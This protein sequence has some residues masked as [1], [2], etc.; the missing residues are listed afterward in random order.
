MVPFFLKLFRAVT[1]R[2]SRERDTTRSDVFPRLYES[3]LESRRVLNGAALFTEPGHLVIDAGQGKNDGVAD[4]FEITKSDVDSNFG[5]QVIVNSTKVWE[6]KASDLASIQINGSNDSDHVV[7][8]SDLPWAGSVRLSG[9]EPLGAAADTLRIE[10]SLSSHFDAILSRFESGTWERTYYRSSEES[11]LGIVASGFEIVEDHSRADLHSIEWVDESS[12]W[13]LETAR[14]L[15]SDATGSG[16]VHVLSS[17]SQ[18]I[19]FSDSNQL[20]LK[21]RNAGASSSLAIGDFSSQGESLRATG[22]SIYATGRLSLSSGGSV[23]LDAGLDGELVVSG[24][25]DVS[26][27]ALTSGGRIVLMG[28]RIEL[29]DGSLLDVTSDGNGGEIYVGGGEG[30]LVLSQRNASSVS[31]SGESVLTADSLRDGNGGRI[32]IWSEEETRIEGIGNLRARGGAWSGDG[33]FIETS[34]RGLLHFIDPVLLTASNGRGGLWLVDPTDI[35]IVSVPTPDTSSTA[36]VLA[37]VIE[38]QLNNGVSVSYVTAAGGDGQGDIL[39]Q[40]SITVTG[41]SDATLT[42]TAGRDIVFSA[43]GNIAGNNRLSLQ[44]NA[45]RNIETDAASL[46]ALREL[47]LTA[48]NGSVF[49]GAVSVGD[50]AGLSGYALS[51]SSQILTST[52][53]ITSG[54]GDI[55]FI[56]T[57]TSNTSMTLDDINTNAGDLEIRAAATVAFVG[58]ANSIQSTAGQLRIRG[59]TVATTIGLGNGVSGQLVLNNA[60]ISAIGSGFTSG[61]QIGATGQSGDIAFAGL[62][63]TYA[64]SLTIM[65]DGGADVDFLSNITLSGSGNSLSVQSDSTSVIEL[66]SNITTNGGDITILSGRLDVDGTATRTLATGGVGGTASVAGDV[67]FGASSSIAGIDKAASLLIDTRGVDDGGDVNLSPVVGTGTGI[68]RL[69]I[70]TSGSAT[71][72]TVTLRDVRL[73]RDGTTAAL[74]TVNELDTTPSDIVAAGLI[75]LSESTLNRVGGAIDWGASRVRP[76]LPTSSLELRTRH[77]G[78]AAANNGNDGGSIRFGGV[79]ATGS[80]YFDRIIIDSR[81]AGSLNESG[82]IE[83]TGTGERVLAVDGENGG[84]ATTVGIDVLGRLQ[85]SASNP[86]TFRTNP[87]AVDGLNSLA[88]DLSDAQVVGSGA[89]SLITGSGVLGNT[90]NIAGNVVLGN[91]SMTGAGSSL[92]SDTRGSTIGRT[93]LSDLSDS[94]VSITVAGTFDFRNTLTELIDS[95]TLT[96]LGD[97]NILQLGNVTASGAQGLSLLSE[98]SI[99]TGTVDLNTGSLSI[100]LDTDNDSV[101]ALTTTGAL[102]GSTVTISGSALDDDTVDLGGDVTTTTGALS[103]SNVSSL[104]LQSNVDLRSATNIALATEV[105]AIELT[106]ATGTNVIQITGAS[107]I[108]QLV[109][110][111]GTGNVT[112]QLLSDHSID[113][114]GDVVLS[115]GLLDATI[116]I[117]TART[118]T[119]FRSQGVQA[120][121]MTVRGGD[122]LNDN[123]EFNGS[124]D[125]GDVGLLVEDV[126]SIE[127]DQDIISDG[128]VSL[129]VGTG[130]S[131]LLNADITTQGADISIL[132]GRLDVDGTATRTLST[133]GVGGTATVAGDVLFGST[134]SIAGVDGPASLLVDTRAVDGGGD[135]NL[136]PV[137]GTGTGINRLSIQ[138]SGSATD[139]TVTLRD[140]RL[141][142]DGTTAALFTVNELDTTPSDI[143]AAGLIDLS[144]STL[145]RVGGAIDWGASRV[146]PTLPTSTLE[147]RTSHTGIAVL[148]NG[149]DGGSIRFGGVVATGSDYFDRIIIDSRGAGSL[150]ESGLIELTGT[151]ERVLAVDGENGGDATTVGIDVLGRLQVSASNPLTFRTNPGAVDGLNSL[152]IDLSDAQVVG[153]GALSLI[154][155]SGVLG[156]T[157]NIAGNVVLGNI[158]MTGAG[159]SLTSDTRGSTIGRTQLSDLSDSTVSITVAGTFDFR[160]TL[161]ELI[162]SA[163]LTSLGDANILQLGNVTASGAQGLSLLSEGSISTGTVDLNTGSLSIQLDTDND[164]VSALTTTGALDG[165]T[166]TISGSALDDDTVDLGGDVTTTTGALSFSNVSSLQ[167]QSNVDLRSATNIAF[168]TEV[169]A[170]ELT[171]ATG[172]NVIQIKGA[173]NIMQLVGVGGTGNV[174][175]QLLS[176]HSID[177]LGDVVLSA[178]LLDATIGISTA[179]TDTVF[180]SQGVQARGIS[181]RGNDIAND[182]AEF[183]ALLDLGSSGLLVDTFGKVLIQSNI[184]SSG[185]I[186]IRNVDVEVLLQNGISILGA[187]VQIQSNVESIRLEGNNLFYS[188]ESTGDSN[189]IAL[190]DVETSETSSLFLASQQ[191]IEIEDVLLQPSSTLSIRVDSDGDNVGASLSANDLRAGS[192][193]IQG[194]IQQNDVATISGEVFASTGPLIVAQW[195]TIDFGENVQ[196]EANVSIS[197]VADHVRFGAATLVSAL[198]GDLDIRVN[199]GQVI[200]DDLNVTTQLESRNGSVRLGLIRSDGLLRDV[201]IR[202]DQDVL[203][204]GSDMGGTIAI[205]A[206]DDGL[207]NGSIAS[208]GVIKASEVDL[209]AAT[210][211]GAI[212]AIP[213]QT[214]SIEAWNTLSGDLQL[215][216]TNAT[217]TS[218]DIRSENG[219]NIVLAQAGGSMVLNR[220]QSQADGSPAVGEADIFI[221]STNSDIEVSGTGIQAGGFGRV[222]INAT[223]NSDVD[224][225]SGIDASGGSLAIQSG[226]SI[227]GMGSLVSPIIELAAMSGIGAEGPINT[228]ALFLDAVTVQSDVRIRNLNSNTVTLERI[229]SFSLGSVEFEQT[230]GGN[231]NVIQAITTSG[232]GDVLLSN[233][234]GSISVAGIVSAGGQGDVSLVASGDIRLLPGSVARTSSEAGVFDAEAGDLFQLL[235]GAVIQVGASNSLTES[236]LYRFPTEVSISPTA[237][238]DGVNV[239]AIGSAT[240]VVRLGPLNPTT[241]DKNFAITIDWADGQIDQVPLG[242]RSPLSTF[243]AIAR[244]DAN[245]VPFLIQHQYLGNPNV[246]DPAAP[247]PVLFT[248]TVDPFQRIRISDRFGTADLLTRVIQVNLEVPAAGLFA[249][250]IEIPQVQLISRQVVLAD[251]IVLPVTQ[252]VSGTNTSVE[253]PSSVSEVVSKSERKF[254]LRLVT[255]VNE[256][257]DVR[258]SENIELSEEDLSDL[259]SLFGRLGDNRYR[260]YAVLDGGIEL[261]LRDLYLKKHIPI[262]MDEGFSNELP[263][264]NYLNESSEP[265]ESASPKELPPQDV[266]ASSTPSTGVDTGSGADVASGVISMIASERSFRR[267]ART[268]RNAS[269][270][271]STSELKS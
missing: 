73:V 232:S 15:S 72:G 260:I 152:A 42:L 146:R 89:L 165:S 113:L 224:L 161:T 93:Q 97:A 214:S 74:F 91:I 194:S 60:S 262:E 92:T 119:V 190:A 64:N 170:I 98:G 88:I 105:G 99:S 16:T 17:S 269:K 9:G 37:S 222:F 248:L 24:Q 228:T 21:W 233:S 219:T 193:T 67:I 223:G 186:D 106:G 58:G 212:T 50:G 234:D 35:A 168:A 149:N 32:V 129:E 71:D 196:G 179:R 180:R 31:I 183:T 130:G 154:T 41:G 261:L 79:V 247:I 138:T 205:H 249:L 80:D 259:P 239:D 36:Y 245:G 3:R 51:S 120:R 52:G 108:M 162:D 69:S 271:K 243:P 252:A 181:V 204:A 127:I 265:V 188:I 75:D 29:A 25:I 220:V 169:G 4:T 258:E 150:N 78:S 225:Q 86:L 95:A 6:G 112:L 23:L 235:D 253:V 14:T 55:Q 137:V 22:T 145:N 176:D 155:G 62:A 136:S 151:G 5:L 237:N 19:F 229:Q 132:S 63:Q 59:T 40:A 142:R 208:T 207:G 178:G 27:G 47:H 109:G 87:G 230:G 221:G 184:D 30:G 111:S 187:G 227:G 256:Q 96:S 201:V 238:L 121:G 66:N 218:W 143:V 189:A 83:L 76:T 191:D 264:K 28:D 144:E 101:S 148:D 103:F 175:L 123:V 241:I 210:G 107:N 163:T 153:S 267:A 173:S 156:N 68:N 266:E 199:V 226:A 65:A 43:A 61:I 126:L 13:R 231:L 46:T 53:T 217:A 182:V 257:G 122:P 203:L 8:K 242:S 202:A 195:R 18:S 128:L 198:N 84:D 135:V 255:P 147:L 206:A 251:E 125:L 104:Q 94:T 2:W 141:V 172:T 85:V 100:Q 12:S 174:T 82:L 77:D 211:I 166:V 1:G 26:G 49:L 11:S 38:G 7:V 159:S 81:G 139:G 263:V 133:G 54:G 236:V 20:D 240:L 48:T 160:N 124:L 118:D 131:I 209:F 10:S 70:Q 158:S 254:V 164:S 39:V 177:L 57:E 90:S 110:V 167:L 171:G 33:G 44:L 140:V 45:G 246:S 117:S 250:R 185:L 216:N 270:P 192:I 34:S 115:A 56:A 157:S 116:G 215:I 213:L 134:S 197:N 102:D 114:L 200:L 268:L 244:F